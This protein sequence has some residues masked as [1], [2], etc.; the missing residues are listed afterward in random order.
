MIA[1]DY[2]N[3][4]SNEIRFAPTR[5]ARGVKAALSELASRSNV[6]NRLAT[7]LVTTGLGL[8]A[9]VAVA[10]TTWTNPGAG[11]WNNSGQL[12]GWGACWGKC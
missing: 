2:S 12:D 1:S 4:D 7:A 8:T 3:V 9:G 6:R 10:Q 11:D 5:L